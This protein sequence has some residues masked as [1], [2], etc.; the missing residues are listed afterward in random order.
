M[1]NPSTN[2]LPQDALNYC[3]RKLLGEWRM[4]KLRNG[5]FQEV[6]AFKTAGDDKMFIW[7]PNRTMQWHLDGTSVTSNELDIMEVL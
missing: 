5:A 2:Q 1:L 7:A 6:R 3:T 4:S